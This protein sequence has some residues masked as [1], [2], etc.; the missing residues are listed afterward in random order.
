MRLRGLNPRGRI[1]G[2]GSRGQWLRLK[3]GSFRFGLQRATKPV[4]LLP[5]GQGREHSDRARGIREIK[6]EHLKYRVK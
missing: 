6:D 4:L 1:G 2:S 3:R 5:E